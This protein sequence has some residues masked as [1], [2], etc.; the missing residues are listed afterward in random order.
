MNRGVKNTSQIKNHEN[1]NR[2]VPASF[3]DVFDGHA[4]EIEYHFF[5]MIRIE[6]VTLPYLAIVYYPGMLGPRRQGDARI[7]MI[8]I[9][10]FRFFRAGG[11][12]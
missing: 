12:G 9:A 4:P 8:R 7:L 10:V 2:F 1:P 6:A 5:F 11:P 3:G